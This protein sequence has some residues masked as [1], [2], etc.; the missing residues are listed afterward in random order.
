MSTKSKLL[1]VRSRARNWRVSES[2]HTVSP[3]V[4][5]GDPA[6]RVGKNVGTRQTPCLDGAGP[7]SWYPADTLRWSTCTL[8]M[9]HCGKVG[10][11]FSSFLFRPQRKLWPGVRVSEENHLPILFGNWVDSRKPR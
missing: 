1:V 3:A 9:Q 4:Q 2:T 7:A 6:T 11:C 10:S 5:S 8:L